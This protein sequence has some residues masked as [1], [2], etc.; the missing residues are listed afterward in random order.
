MKKYLIFCFLIL[1]SCQSYGLT[2]IPFFGQ[3]ITDESNT[4]TEQQQHDLDLLLIEFERPRTD[5]AQ[6]AV[7]MINAL[8][9]ETIE[10]YADRVFKR[11]Q[12]GKQ[13]R[14]NGVLLLIIKDERRMRIE[15]GYGLEGVITDL[16]ASHVIREQ[17]APQFRQDNYYQGIYNGLSTLIHY[18]EQE[19]SSPNDKQELTFKTLFD[20]KFGSQLIL[21]SAFSFFVCLVIGKI[22]PLNLFRLHA[23]RCLSTALLNGLSVSGYTLWHGNTLLLS[24]QML[25]LVFVA[26]AILNGI[27]GMPTNKGGRNNRRSGGFGGGG[28][29]GFG[30]GGGFGGGGGGF[31]GG[32]GASGGW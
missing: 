6:I 26:S 30:S 20:S 15:V 11:W 21:Y 4:L 1:A 29:G 31:S 7:L 19:P 9:G 8:D 24:L 22:V 5:G 13:G 14:D 16:T 27:L 3:R 23:G 2:D 28:G 18:I 10:Q 12:I 17:L 32:G 25:F